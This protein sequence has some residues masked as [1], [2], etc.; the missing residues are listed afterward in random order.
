MSI[1]TLEA[2]NRILRVIDDGPASALDTGGTTVEAEAETYL[3]ESNDR[4]LRMGWAFNHTRNEEFTVD[5][6]DQIVFDGVSNDEVLAV[7]MGTRSANLHGVLRNNLLY[8]IKNNRDTWPD[9]D[10]I[11]L[12]VTYPVAFTQLSLAMQ[13]LVIADASL[14]FQRAKK[15][16]QVDEALL[17]DEYTRALVEAKQEDAMQVPTNLFSTSHARRHRGGRD[18]T[19]YDMYGGY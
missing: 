6:S 18:F 3:D 1:T 17:R 15:R 9:D 16:G 4:V 7:S 8:D 10:T 14:H 2:V 11:Y 19:S 5:G 13:E 12:N